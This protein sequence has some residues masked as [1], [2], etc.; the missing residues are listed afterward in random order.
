MSENNSSRLPAHIGFIM[1]GNGRWAKKRGLER[2]FGHKEGARTFRKIVSYCKELGIKYI[3][4]Y[5]FSTENWKRPKD[6]VESIM[7]LF[8]Q[9]LDEV[10]EHT[11]E[12]VRVMFIGDKSAFDEKFRNKM[13]A[14]EEDSKDFDAMTLIL[15]I[16]YGG[17]DDIIFAAKQAAELV[18]EGTI[19]SSQI[20]ESLFSNLL[21]TKGIPDVD[22]IIRPSGEL[23][24]SNFLIWQA[25]YAEYYFTDILWPDFDKKDLDKALDEFKNRKRRFGGV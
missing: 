12:N 23:R 13:I 19:S 25:A 6:E 8:D 5:A 16:N 4:F 21:Y 1:D 11:K 2:K 9:Y 10:R 15:A 14:L 20:D 18:K 24:L 3:T 17:R 7:A 22:Y